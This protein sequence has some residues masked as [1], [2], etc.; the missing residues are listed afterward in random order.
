MCVAGV[1]P[2]L[3]RLFVAPAFERANA[4]FLCVRDEVQEFAGGCSNFIVAA[5]SSACEMLSPLR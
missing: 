5:F 1:A 3:E 4:A 2:V